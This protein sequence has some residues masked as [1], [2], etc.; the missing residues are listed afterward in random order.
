MILTGSLEPVLRFAA[1][2]LVIAPAAL[3]LLAFGAWILFAPS[4]SVR[5]SETWVANGAHVGLGVWLLNVLTVAFALW[6]WFFLGVTFIPRER[7]QG[8]VLEVANLIAPGFVLSAVGWGVSRAW[9][10]GRSN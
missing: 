7:M 6:A 9:W 4:D 2:L 5:W 3:A 8:T 10:R 1:A